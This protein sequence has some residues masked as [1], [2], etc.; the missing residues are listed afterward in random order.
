MSKIISSKRSGPNK[1]SYIYMMMRKLVYISSSLIWNRQKIDDL[2]S[3]ILEH[4]SIMNAA[5][6]SINFFVFS[7]I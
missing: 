1:A 7:S 5:T 2:P 6:I 3:M 4:D